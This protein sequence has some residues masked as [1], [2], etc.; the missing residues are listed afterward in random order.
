MHED[1][2]AA[3]AR[4]ATDAS[5]GCAMT[6]DDRNDGRVGPHAFTLAVEPWCRASNRQMDPDLAFAFA[7]VLERE[8]SKPWLGN[9]TTGQLIDELRARSDLGYRTRGR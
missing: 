7:E 4:Q 6:P 5:N 8:L 3:Q 1:K 9:A 2:L